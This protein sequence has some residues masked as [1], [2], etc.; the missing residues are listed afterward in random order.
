ME[1]QPGWIGLFG[2][3]DTSTLVGHLMQNPVYTLDIENIYNL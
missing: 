3:Y 2:V 1:L